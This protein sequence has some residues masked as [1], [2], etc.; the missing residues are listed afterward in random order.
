MSRAPICS[1]DIVLC[2]WGDICADS[3]GLVELR[4][5]DKTA[6]ASGSLELLDSDSEIVVC[7]D[8]AS[9]LLY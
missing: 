7:V 6:I 3:S 9:S 1:L 2:A 4:G 8:V 5:I